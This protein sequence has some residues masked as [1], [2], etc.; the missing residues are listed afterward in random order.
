MYW[1]RSSEL[2]GYKVSHG[3]LQHHHHHRRR[4]PH[5]R[6]HNQHD[7]HQLFQSNLIFRIST[8]PLSPRF[9]LPSFSG[10]DGLTLEDFRW[11]QLNAKIIGQ[12]SLPL[13]SLSS[14]SLLYC[15]PPSQWS[16]VMIYHAMFLLF[17]FIVVQITLWA[18]GC[19]QTSIPRWWY[20]DDHFC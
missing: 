16:S 12:L 8:T 1:S 6:Q 5:L 10:W 19:Y 11:L 4:H 17:A 9:A 18:R 2:T 20:L 15:S 3:Y 13:C 7:M 14:I